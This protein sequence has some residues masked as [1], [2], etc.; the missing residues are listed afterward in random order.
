MG[1]SIGE[2]TAKELAKKEGVTVRAIG[3]PFAKFH[4]EGNPLFPMPFSQSLQL[5]PE[6]IEALRPKRA[7]I[8]KTRTD[9]A[10][11]AVNIAMIDAGRP[12]EVA[13]NV[14]PL[15]RA[16]TFLLLLVCAMCAIVSTSNMF[17]I[18]MQI[19]GSEWVASVLTSIF[20]VSPFIVLYAGV[21]RFT[22][23]LVAGICITYEVFCNATGIYRGFANLGK[24]VPYEVWE[25]GG[26]I[27]SIS[28]VTT[29]EA[30]P[31]AL[32]VSVAMAA[33]VAAL[34]LICLTEIKRQK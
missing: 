1:Y 29:F 24:G 22:S 23:W 16:R 27:D 34:F 32:F 13:P 11:P 6:Q 25:P 18:S 8:K 30:R 5:S 33:I 15:R 28:R 9:T 2:M 20:T 10:P 31:C 17:E 19:K 14:V 3:I 21:R 12:N 26:F 7:P 4:R